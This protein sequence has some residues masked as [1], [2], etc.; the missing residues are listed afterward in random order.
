M[1]KILNLILGLLLAAQNPNLGGTGAIG[2]K[3][4]FGGAG[5]SIVFDSSFS[6]VL[7][8]TGTASFSWNH[9]VGTSGQHAALYA[10]VAM[11]STGSLAGTTCTF[12]GVSM[13]LIGT[14]STSG[15]S[16][17]VEFILVNPTTGTHAISCT[18][19]GS[20]GTGKGVSLSF[21]DVNQ[22]TPNR[23]AITANTPNGGTASV[24]VSN[25]VAGDVV[26]D[27]VTVYNFP[28][29]PDPSQ[30][31]LL[32]FRSATLTFGVSTKNANGS[33]TMQW[34]GSFSNWCEVGV[35]LVP[36]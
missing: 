32:N 16:G 5:T 3:A 26:I 19:G 25:A 35:A 8:T 11:T 21:F 24:V 23:T 9:T 7:I 18:P 28:A 4:N 29:T 14:K 27:A 17:T 30:T 33:T 15:V 22:S 20:V 31:L 6:S 34:T 12:N 13:T 1:N 36:G 2:G 10:S